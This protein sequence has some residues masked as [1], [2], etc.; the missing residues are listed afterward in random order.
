MAN[1]VDD[2]AAFGA[3]LKML[4]VDVKNLDEGLD[5]VKKRLADLENRSQK[6]ST[7]TSGVIVETKVVTSDVCAA[8]PEKPL[9][10]PKKQEKEKAKEK[11]KKLS[12]RDKKDK[13][14]KQ[15]SESPK[16]AKKA[17]QP[18]PVGVIVCENPQSLG[19][20]NAAAEGERENMQIRSDTFHNLSDK[21][22][23]EIEIRMAVERSRHTTEPPLVY[24]I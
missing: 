22:T 3:E 1:N 7:T 6:S 9:V 11:E 20:I 24:K 14:Q 8:P 15:L 10:S 2:A 13:K 16:G 17:E 23:P 5:E 19:D 21:Q 4:Q 18:I 12:A